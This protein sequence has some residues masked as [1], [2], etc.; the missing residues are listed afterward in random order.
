MTRLRPL[1]LLLLP[2]LL[3]AG[4]AAALEF[5]P[6]SDCAAYCL[7]DK[8]GDQ[9]DKADSTTNST[10]I[11]CEDRDFSTTSAGIKFKNCQECLQ[12]SEH[13]NG[14]ESDMHWFMCKLANKPPT[15]RRTV[16]SDWNGLAAPAQ[17]AQI[18][19]ETQN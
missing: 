18:V 19:G 9:F 16:H 8:D 15:T 2:L 5:A 12:S 6:G 3:L 4:S 17:P 7:D 11:I 14:T 10:D 13:V 1:P